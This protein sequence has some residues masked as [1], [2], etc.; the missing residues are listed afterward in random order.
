[1]ATEN[2]SKRRLQHAS[3]GESSMPWVGSIGGQVHPNVNTRSRSTIQVPTLP[4][5][6]PSWDQV[7]KTPPI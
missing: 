7:F 4:Q 5:Q 3:P 1:M 2:A 6:H